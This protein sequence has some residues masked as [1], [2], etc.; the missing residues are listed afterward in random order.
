MDHMIKREDKA[1]RKLPQK[2]CA[3]PIPCQGEHICH[4]EL[5]EKHIRTLCCVSTENSIHFRLQDTKRNLYV[6]INFSPPR[7][8][9][10]WLFEFASPYFSDRCRRAAADPK[11]TNTLSFMMIV[12]WKFWRFPSRPL[13]GRL[14]CL[15]ILFRSRPSLQIV[16]VISPGP[17]ISNSSRFDTDEAA[18]CGILA[19]WCIGWDWD[20]K[21][22][23]A[24]FLQ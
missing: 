13:Q 3:V 23:S 14:N 15:S 2:P 4:T 24:G 11:R 5:Y 10:R 19:R 6:N 8:V 22:N 17:W 20:F 1:A 12:V 21:R 16:Q 7:F 9:C 18:R